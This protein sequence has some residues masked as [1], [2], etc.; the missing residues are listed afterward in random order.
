METGLYLYNWINTPAYDGDDYSVAAENGLVQ[1][2]AKRGPLAQLVG[3]NPRKEGQPLP[4]RFEA[5][6]IADMSIAE[7]V[8]PCARTV[9]AACVA[10]NTRRACPLPPTSRTLS[11]VSWPSR[12][13]SARTC[14][15]SRKPKPK[16]SPLA[17]LDMPTKSA[18]GLTKNTPRQVAAAK[19]KNQEHAEQARAASAKPVRV[20]PRAL[21][22]RRVSYPVGK[23]LPPWASS[24][25]N[26]FGCQIVRMG[27]AVAP[28]D[29][30]NPFPTTKPHVFVKDFPGVS[31]ASDAEL[32]GL[33]WHG[34]ADVYEC[35]RSE[36]PATPAP[37][38]MPDRAWLY[39]LQ[40]RA[41][42]GRPRRMDRG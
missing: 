25:A 21:G 18:N 16:L 42:K 27:G 39:F 1:I 4:K 5:R 24:L 12:P 29:F 38:D 3:L 6:L 20:A 8:T 40:D 22:L 23:P 11:F 2:T 15:A 31:L 33:T 9:R 32:E 26:G 17:V 7:P 19:K 35:P 30:A 34:D 14:A 10:W 41:A 28:K 36:V 13:M 37:R